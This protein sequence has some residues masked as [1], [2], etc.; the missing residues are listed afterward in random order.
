MAVTTASGT[1][2]FV[3]PATALTEIDFTTAESALADFEAIASGSWVEVKEIEDYGAHGDESAE[4]TFASVGDARIRKFKGARNAGTMALI[5]GADPQDA[6]QLA[7]I[8]AEKTKFNYAF[9]IIYPDAPSE[10]FT[11]S[12]EYFLGLVMS[13]P[14]NVGTNDNVMR[15]TFNVGI[16]SEVIEVLSEAVSP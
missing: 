15:R 11:N 3:G 6:G 16:N 14:K 5:V 10:D 4:V 7:M 1:R 2:F 12:V 9:K 13:R 8:A